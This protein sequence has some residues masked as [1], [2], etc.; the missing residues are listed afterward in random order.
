MSTK[1]KLGIFIGEHRCY[2]MATS[3]ESL[4]KG[5]TA[6]ESLRATGTEHWIRSPIQWTVP[7]ARIVSNER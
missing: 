6:H 5:A 7:T 3:V 2:L 1:T 4:F